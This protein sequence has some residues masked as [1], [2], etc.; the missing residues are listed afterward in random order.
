M[1]K[2]FLFVALFATVFNYRS[3]SQ[4]SI[5]LSQLITHYFSVKNALVSGNSASASSSAVSFLE[6]IE[7]VGNKVISQDNI[8]LLVNDANKIAGI[9]DIKRQRDYFAGFSA[10]MATVARTVK[11]SDQPVYLDY[12]PMKKAVWLS[13]DKEIKNPYYGTAMLTCD[14]VKESF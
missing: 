13:S 8:Q 5:N 11:L 6:A 12:C 9:N 14:T 2:S 10:N 7:S 1:K 3:F 4:D